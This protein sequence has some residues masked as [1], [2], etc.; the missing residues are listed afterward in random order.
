M[1]IGIC[2]GT[3]DP[4]H[5]GHLEPVLAVREIMEWDRLLYV[6][7]R[8]QPFKADRDT[9]SG[10]HRFAMTVLATEQ[11]D[12][13]WV[14][15]MEL[16]RESISYTVDTLE[17]LR[18]EHPDATLDWIIGDDNIAQLGGW[19]SLPRILQLAN[20]AVLTRGGSGVRPAA[21]DIET[22]DGTKIPVLADGALR[23]THGALVFARNATIPISSTEIR[24]RVRAGKPIDSFVDARV[25]RYI[26][27]NGLY[28]AS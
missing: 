10:P 8:K 7:A 28:R 26:D 18:T 15:P 5:Y 23:G 13:I 6:P 19:K 22:S 12:F 25:A 24:Q 11:F 2:G 1:R 14:S 3:F 16:D 17:I 20:F 21:A 9:A 4:F 27:H